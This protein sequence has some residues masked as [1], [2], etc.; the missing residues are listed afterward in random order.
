MKYILSVCLGLLLGFGL[1]FILNLIITIRLNTKDNLIAS[2]AVN[3]YI[4]WGELPSSF[5]TKPLLTRSIT[6]VIGILI[7]V[8]VSVV[9]LRFTGQLFNIS[10]KMDWF[11]ISL[12]ISMIFGSLLKLFLATKER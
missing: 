10:T 9:S 2:E 8:L 6:L 3:H 7:L 5:K 12:G 4:D 1:T 11:L